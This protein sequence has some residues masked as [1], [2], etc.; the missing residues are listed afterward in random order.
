M[1]SESFYYHHYLL[2]LTFRAGWPWAANRTKLQ[3][4]KPGMNV[5]EKH[6]TYLKLRRINS[7]GVDPKGRRFTNELDLI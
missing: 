7:E 5:R 4:S 2:T 3:W 6:L 1:K